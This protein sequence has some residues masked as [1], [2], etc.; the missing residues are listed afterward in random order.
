MVGEKVRSVYKKKRKR[1][2]SVK[3]KQKKSM[4]KPL[5]LLTKSPPQ[6]RAPSGMKISSPTW[7]LKKLLVPPERKLNMPTRSFF[8]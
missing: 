1:N 3:Q 8:F 4:K 5:L 6:L 2:F 7:T